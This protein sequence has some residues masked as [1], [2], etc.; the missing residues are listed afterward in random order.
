MARNAKA[1]SSRI[2]IRELRLG[3][4]ALQ[5]IPEF[6][7]CVLAPRP[8]SQGL[9][10]A[11]STIRFFQEVHSG[12]TLH[13]STVWRTAAA[14]STYF[15]APIPRPLLRWPDERHR[16]K[17]RDPQLGWLSAHVRAAAVGAGCVAGI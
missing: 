5:P 9:K 14:S 7:Y 13:V 3:K 11:L 10:P 1:G 4:P 8:T 16:Y 6:S 17:A 15:A 2:P 12:T